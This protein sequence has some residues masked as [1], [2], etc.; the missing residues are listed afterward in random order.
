MERE[1][2]LQSLQDLAD[3]LY[4]ENIISVEI[5]TINS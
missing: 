5:L 1:H 2:S 4:P 3:D